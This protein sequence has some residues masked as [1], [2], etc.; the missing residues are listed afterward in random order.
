[1][2]AATYCS[3][4]NSANSVKRRDLGFVRRFV[5]YRGVLESLATP[6]SMYGLYQAF[7]YVHTSSSFLSLCLSLY[8]FKQRC[9]TCLPPRRL[10]TKH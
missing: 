7:I 4:L 5:L 6:L 2:I 8:A 10:P 3:V 9:P 1:M